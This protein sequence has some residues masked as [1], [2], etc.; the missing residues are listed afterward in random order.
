MNAQYSL[1]SEVT[2]QMSDRSFYELDSVWGWLWHYPFV[3]AHCGEAIV[4]EEALDSPVPMREE[5]GRKEG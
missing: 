4:G 2:T 1:H 3:K 5:M